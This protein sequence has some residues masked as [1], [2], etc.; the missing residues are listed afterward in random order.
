MVI[1]RVRRTLLERGLI[2]PGMRVL[3]ACSGGP[4]SGAMLF[5]LQRLSSEL[6]FT[7]EAAS[8]DHGLREGAKADLAT[9]GAQAAAAGVRFHALQV[10][11]T[12]SASLQAEARAARYGALLRLA[13]H[14]GAARI[15]VGHTLDDQAET[16]VLRILR[17]SGVL[18]LRGIDPSRPDGV[19]RPLIDCRRAEVAAFAQRHCPEIA[20]DP[21]NADR[22]FGRSRVRADVLPVLQREDRAIVEHL[23]DLAEEARALSASLRP[24]AEALLA[25]SIQADDIIDVST[26]ASSPASIRRLALRIWLERATGEEPR[27]SHLAA[28]DRAMTAAGEVWLSA[29]WMVRSAGN[30]RLQL[31]RDRL[32]R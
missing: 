3:A 13:S 11:V 12:G 22:R 28:V 2:A 8:V 31:G 17:G 15:A 5:A 10:S 30:G 16:V 24:T 18:G 23:A 27:R 7:L 20:S 21:S 9:A 32:P 26:W 25:A 29:G 1:A 14:I 4:D 19:I 6:G